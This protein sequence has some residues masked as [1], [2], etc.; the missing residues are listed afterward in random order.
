MAQFSSI[1]TPFEQRRG[2]VERGRSVEGRIHKVFITINLIGS[3]EVLADVNFPVWFQE[4]PAV[5]SGGEMAENEVIVDTQFPTISVI[6]KSWVKQKRDLAE[7]FT[8]ATLIV[9]TSGV[10]GQKMIAH[11]QAEGKALRNPLGGL[12]GL[13]DTI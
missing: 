13:G 10:P 7:Y 12:G 6:V 4:K 8:G 3:G 9:V 2:Q 5:S 11:F 1:Q